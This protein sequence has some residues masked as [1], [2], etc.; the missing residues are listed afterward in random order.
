MNEQGDIRDDEIRIIGGDL[1]SAPQPRRNGWL[2]AVAGALV[3]VVIAVVAIFVF[4]G[5]S[6]DD[7]PLSSIAEQ[8]VEEQNVVPE[9]FDPYE[10]ADNDDVVIQPETGRFGSAVDSL[11][12]GFCE[13]RDM[14][15]N[16]VQLRIYIPHNAD[17]TL[18]VGKLDREDS[19]IIYAAEASFIRADNLDILGA[20]VLEGEPLAWGLSVRGYCSSIDGEVK[21]GVA[22]NSPLFEE[23]I[24]KGGYFFRQYG[25]VDEG[26]LVENE[27][28][29]KSIRRA[30]CERRGEIFMVESLNKESFHDFAQALVDLDIDNAVNLPGS[31]AYG[32]A[33]DGDDKVHE[34]GTPNFYTGRG[35][36][37]K[38]TNYIVWRRL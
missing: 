31:E 14:S 15:M 5:E 1:S 25:L 24:E 29:N 23:A 9:I 7:K 32:W 3:V 16:D 33:I 13:I 2:K 22:D 26:V 6:A 8:G 17:M 19:S 10:A 12:R 30:I 36:M 28:K 21:V 34:F 27:P 38:N 4:G 35:K 20:F 37:P 18:H 11:A